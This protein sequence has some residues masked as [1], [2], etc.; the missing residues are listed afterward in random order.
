MASSRSIRGSTT[1]SGHG[2][3][4]PE[5]VRDLVHGALFTRGG[6]DLARS[7]IFVGGSDVSA[8]EAVLKAVTD[9]FFPGFS[10]SV[11]LDANGANTTASAAV[12]AAI[13]GMGGSVA[14]VKVAVLGGTGPVGRRVALLLSKLGAMVSVGSR[15]EE[16]AAA[17]AASVADRGGMPIGSFST[18]ADYDLLANLKGVA[19]VVAAGA[20]GATL[21]PDP[22]R[23]SLA[24]LKV[25]ID[26]NA[27]PPLGVE[28]VKSTDRGSRA[29]RRP[30]L[31][32]ARRGRDEDEDPQGGRQ[33]AVR[34]ERSSPG[35]RN[36]LRDWPGD[37]LELRGAQSMKSILA[38]AFVVLLTGA[39]QP[40]PMDLYFIDV[41]GGAATLLVTPSGES[42]LIDTGWAGFADRDPILIEKVIKDVA[43]L[44]HL[45]HLVTTHWH[46]DHFGGVEGLARR[47]RID[48][49][50]DRGLPDPAA[51]DGDRANFPDGPL[52]GDKLGDPYRKA[53][54]GKRKAL[55]AGD[56]LPLKGVEAVVLAS[57][58][59]VIEAGSA[60]ANS[61]CDQ[62]P[63]DLAVDR[64]DNA[65]S[66]AIRFRLGK[67]DFLDCGD[68]TWNVE[69]QLVCPLD[70]IGPI[71]LFQVTHH[72]M[73]ISN[74]PTLLATIAPT[75]AIMNNGPTKGW[76]PATVKRL[77][78]L[79]SIQASYQLHRNRRGK[80]EENS[81]PAMTARDG[82]DGVDFIHV[83]VAPTGLTYQV[84]IGESGAV[85]TFQSR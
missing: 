35:R 30:V 74:H 55:M 81:E 15:S 83:Q 52:P 51:P 2:G 79:P 9:S 62:A 41:K 13:E 31:G 14:G 60:P 17:A 24:D 8:A 46:A 5:T 34:G 6:A 25:A 71:D 37:D 70:R 72:G 66:L 36:D 61:L 12:L 68:L 47:I 49:Y 78:A 59:K 58:G 20:A 54:E 10:V 50:W 82:S 33:V 48:H 75:V 26:L 1:S 29:R 7:A 27:V 28:G 39:D 57:G 18:V 40:Q 64:S 45:D 67:F 77:K 4:K 16:R 22:I 73:D 42:V 11:M 32:S 43:K 80:A 63:A 53:S 56:V 21:L 76:S 38:V 3:I 85:K 44:K 65:R 19:I 69:K 23:K 84:Q